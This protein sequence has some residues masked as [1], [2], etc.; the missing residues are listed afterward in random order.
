MGSGGFIHCEGDE[1]M[2]ALIKILRRQPLTS[3][4]ALV[5]SIIALLMKLMK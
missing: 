5:I 2:K 3:W 1:E 4:I